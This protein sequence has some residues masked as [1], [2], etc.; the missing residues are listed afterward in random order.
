MQFGRR[1]QTTWSGLEIIGFPCNQFGGQEPGTEA[2]IEAFVRAEF[3]ITFPLTEKIEVNGANQHPIY[4]YLHAYFPEDIQWNF[5]KVGPFSSYRGMHFSWS[6]QFLIDKNG[7]PA[8]KF[9]TPTAPQD[10]ENDITRLLFA[11]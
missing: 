9:D 3:G 1:T 5:E 8:K 6:W 7:I 2:E 4:R 11:T 10:L